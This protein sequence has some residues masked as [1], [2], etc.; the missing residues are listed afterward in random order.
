MAWGCKYHIAWVPKRR[1]K[2]VFGK[3][4]RGIGA[5]LRRLCEH[6]GDRITRREG[7]YRSYTPV[8]INT[9]EVFS[10]SDCGIFTKG[11]MKLFTSVPQSCY[12]FTYPT[13]AKSCKVDYPLKSYSLLRVMSVLEILKFCINKSCNNMVEIIITEAMLSQ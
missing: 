10:S 11:S 1:R 13:P 9:N 4:Q 6:K 5:I 2:V 3:L 12:C 7:V 8:H